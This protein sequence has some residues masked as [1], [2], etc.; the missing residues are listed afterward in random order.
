MGAGNRSR[1]YQK[2]ERLLHNI[3]DRVLCFHSRLC[4]ST[5]LASEGV[6][7]VICWHTTEAIHDRTQL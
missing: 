2:S 1:M 5:S 3:L 7:R 4:N 6:V